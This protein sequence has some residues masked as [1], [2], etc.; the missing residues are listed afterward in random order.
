VAEN[1]GGKTMIKRKNMIAA[2]L[3]NAVTATALAAAVSVFGSGGAFAESVYE[4][5]DVDLIVPHSVAGV[6]SQ[7]AQSLA[8]HIAKELGARSVRVKNEQ[9]GGGVRGS[10]LVWNSEADGMTFS[11]VNIPTLVVTQL[12]DSPAVLFDALK[13]TYLGRV[14]AYPR[15]LFTGAQSGIKSV[16]DL[17]A[18]KR[19]FIYAAQGIDEDFYTTIVLADVLG[20]DI[21]VITGY[22]GDADTSL[23]VIRG[24]ADGHITSWTQ[25]GPAV[26]AGEKTPVLIA[27]FDRIP[28]AP[29]V[30][31]AVEL[32]GNDSEL[33]E[34]MNAN[35]SILALGRGFFGPPNMDPEARDQLREAISTVLNDPAVLAELAGKGLPV[36]FASA[37]EQEANVRRVFAAGQKLKPLFAEALASV[38]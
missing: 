25:S 31:T 15:L 17:K 11:L 1:S 34:L 13:F 35:A 23:A 5:K 16:E 3:R 22:E 27:T 20:Y 21:K 12:T 9:G 7:Y 10:N 36:G 37:E 32:V 14:D 28:E 38:Q 6:M 8:P 18:L 19:P 24:D 2:R 29:D 30:P 4:G 33:A 26:K